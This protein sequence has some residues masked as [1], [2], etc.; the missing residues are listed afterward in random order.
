MKPAENRTVTPIRTPPHSIESEQSLIGSLLLDNQ[1]LDRIAGIVTEA[2]F[3]RDDHRRIFRHIAALIK[4][5]N[6]ADAV[7]VHESLERA[8]ESEQAGG[9]AYLGEI[10]NNT[11]S[12]ANAPGYA[13]LV[14]D[15][16]LRRKLITAADELQ[17]NAFTSPDIDALVRSHEASVA[18]L[19]DGRATG[20]PL[21]W[22]RL[23][24]ASEQLCEIVEDLLTAGAM[25]VFYGESNSGKTYLALDLAISIARGIPWL[26]KKTVQAP[27]IYVAAEGARTI[28]NRVLSYKRHHRVD[29]FPLGIV[30]TSVDLLDSAAD[31]PKLV[32][33][34]ERCAQDLGQRPSLVV[35]DTLARA[36]AGG[37]ENAPEDMGA[38]VRNSDLIRQKTGVHVMWIHHSGKD[39]AK[40]ARG[41]SSLRAATDSEI[42][43][44]HDP[45]TEIRTAT[46]TKQRDLG[47]NGLVLAAKLRPVSIGTN[48]W[49]KTITACVV[50]PADYVAPIKEPHGSVQKR[51]LAILGKNA[52]LKVDL[53]KF[54]EERGE[55]RTSAYRAIDRLLESKTIEVGFDGQL[56]LAG[57]SQ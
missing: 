30:G 57:F 36:M 53:A 48:Q 3:Y 12:S 27:A 51:V 16:A 37:N 25:S 33:T 44:K 23:I 13:R 14:R 28:Q 47:S 9:L 19:I 46:V 32:E 10:A 45:V 2:D 26:G 31:T 5:G 43:V 11:P 50:E 15:N 18:G 39:S 17:A 21:A 8:R 22:A 56:R 54:L 38:L 7:T 6:P 20:L 1:C 40:G 34:I 55:R 52:M 24:D 35:I 41:H 4:A 29:D 49:G 42:E